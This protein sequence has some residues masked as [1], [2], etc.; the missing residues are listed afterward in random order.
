MSPPRTLEAA[1]AA[2][3]DEMMRRVYAAELVTM[4]S[5]EQQQFRRQ[6]EA[7]ERRA[8]LRIVR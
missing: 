1:R 6:L 2:F 5:A 4:T 3:V 8:A 7:A